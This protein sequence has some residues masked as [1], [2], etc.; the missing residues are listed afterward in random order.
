MVTLAI[1]FAAIAFPVLAQPGLAPPQPPNLD[2]RVP[3]RASAPKGPA[4]RRAAPRTDPSPDATTPPAVAPSPEIRVSNTPRS[5]VLLEE[6]RAGVRIRLDAPVIRWT[7]E[8]GYVYPAADGFGSLNEPGRPALP[9]RIERIAIPAGAQP[10]LTILDAASSESPSGRVGPVKTWIPIDAGASERTARYD[11]DPT[12]Y[13]GGDLYPAS[14]PVRLG[15]T[16]F[17]REQPYVEL[18]FTPVL[19][20][21]AS[22]SSRVYGSVTVEVDFGMVPVLSEPANDPDFE[23]VYDNGL[24]NARQARAFRG[25]GVTPSVRS[26]AE[27]YAAET[28]VQSTKYK[29]SVNRDG[30]Y[31]L[32]PSWVAT[33]A[34]D[35]LNF[36]PTRYRLDCLGAQIPITVIDADSNGTFNGSDYIEFVGQ[37]LTW[38]LLNADVWEAGDY[39][40]TNVYWLYADN[41]SGVRTTTRASAPQNIYA[42]PLDFSETIHHE[43]N[44]RFLGQLP[45]DPV[46]HFYQDPPVVANPSPSSQTYSM[47]TPGVSTDTATASI[48]VRLLG[49]NYPSNYHRSQ[50]L[51][52]AAPASLTSDWDGFR[53]FT[54]GQDDGPATFAQSI[55][56]GDGTPARADV[57]VNLPL[58]RVVGVPITRDIVYMNWIEL[59]YGRKF[60]VDTDVDGDGTVVDDQTLTF[61]ALNPAGGTGVQFHITGLSANTFALYEMTKLVSGVPI[62][63]PVRLTGATVTGASAP[64]SV[65]FQIVNDPTLPP[66]YKRR[67]VISTITASTSTGDFVPA[68]VKPD[69]PS[70]LHSP[71]AGVD[72]L[73]IANP[74]VLDTTP[75]SSWQQL[76]S[77]RTAQGLRVTVVSTEDVYDEFS[78][79]IS[80]P[81]A[82]RDFITYVYANWPRI[83]PN[84]P[85]R[86]VLLVGDGTLDYKNNLGNAGNRNFVPAYMRSVSTSSVLGYMSDETY[87]STVSG[88]DDL[89]D[90]YLG[91]W[92]VH[93]PAETNGVAQKM[94]SYE[95]QA[96]GQPWQSDVV[97]IADDEEGFE[98][99]Q[100]NQIRDYLNPISPPHSYHKA[101][102]RQIELAHPCPGPN[103]WDLSVVA[104]EMK[105]RITHQ[106]NG[107]VVD[108]GRDIGPGA[109]LMSYV[110]HGS[111]QNWGSNFSFLTNS[112]TAPDDIDALN[113]GTKLPFVLVADCLTGGFAATSRPPSVDLNYTI[114]DD[115]LVTAGKGAIGVL[116][117]SHLTFNNGHDT[118]LNTFFGEAYGRKKIR[119]VGKLLSAIQ[120]VFQTAGDTVALQGYTLVADPA[121]N[122]IIPAPAPPTN[123]VATPG[124]HQ[125]TVT[126]TAS[127]QASKYNV[128]Q[129]TAADGTYTLIGPAVTGTSFPSLNLTNCATYY[130]VVTSLDTGGFEGAW[131]GLNDGCGTGGSCVRATPTNPSAP[132][133]PS[134]LTA[135]DNE[136][137]GAVA[138][139]WTA[140][141]SAQDVDSYKIYWGTTSVNLNH[142]V[143]GITGT[144][145]TVY[146]LLNNQAY[147]FAL[148]ASNC[149]HGEG[150]R[151]STVS[152]MPHRIEGIKPPNSISDLR[153]TRSGSNALLQWTVPTTNIYGQATTVTSQEVYMGTTPNFTIDVA[154]RLATV[155]GNATSYPHVNGYS[156]AGNHYYLVVAIDSSANRSGVSNEVPMGI[157]L[158]SV[159]RNGSSL[160]FSWP[161]V[162]LDFD[163]H[164]TIIS[165]YVLYGSISKFRRSD[166]ST[167]TPINSNIP[168]T[169]VSIPLPAGTFYY[170]V[171]AV[172]NRGAMSPW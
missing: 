103:C 138:L 25:T 20:D 140:S 76:V 95:L 152:A 90:L 27:R 30:I 62:L 84:V 131:S 97:F 38:D 24:L 40:D 150:P 16:G 92:P 153:V 51:V 23:D 60:R 110:G 64:F 111:W 120:L 6:Q 101:Y 53:E 59:T 34:P 66:S 169:S 129:S 17:L 74:D 151:S 160:V 57:T 149:S 11:E 13:A 157:D 9:I 44:T 87:Y 117:P 50:I 10:R 112:S 47:N 98:I 132:S 79:G 114:G 46:D 166:I 73:V 133:A 167:M 134:G 145:Y 155:A 171:I 170:S 67:F 55:L 31:R 143:A 109:A 142:S 5:A 52:N 113:N 146:G 100:D 108:P 161:A 33:N 126:W 80:D 19:Y 163:G 12:V 91:R 127:P 122:L 154:H 72:W 36:S 86:Y 21:P 159:V 118:V 43:V 39:T 141:P 42:I 28:L 147:F 107:D 15:K 7:D 54:Q 119:N 75:G 18:L 144:S 125:V 121:L 58:G 22:G 26:D 49:D 78:Y 63:S 3:G 35:L 88:S 115:L 106:F 32:S 14:S 45:T 93:S 135:T 136:T 165:K 89:P 48:K 162:T 69:A 123:V 164:K 61:S 105:Y 71:A 99:V 8:G 130:Y 137:G 172:D 124:N 158:M 94:I 81:Q 4:P 70:S 148:S 96:T 139:Q 168:G 102:E 116:A 85:V 2:A 156:D 82:I 41:G 83:D 104:A 68:S 29:L 1:S 37:A 77:R 128:Y 65:D 56:T